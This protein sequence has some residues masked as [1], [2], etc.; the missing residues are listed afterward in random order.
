[1]AELYEP[2][3]NVDQTYTRNDFIFRLEVLM[4]D[5]GPNDDRL[6]ATHQKNITWAKSFSEDAV[7]AWGIRAD[8]SICP[9]IVN[10]SARAPNSPPKDQ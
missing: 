2:K 6:R 4:A 7:I 1:M 3:F 5:C 8:G 9:Y 10:D